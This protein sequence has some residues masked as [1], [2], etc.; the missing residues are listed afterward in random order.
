MLQMLEELEEGMYAQA[1]G[2]RSCD[3]LDLYQE[4]WTFIKAAQLKAK[5]QGRRQG[6]R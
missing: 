3:Q 2:V 5:V 6:A 4:A 1:A